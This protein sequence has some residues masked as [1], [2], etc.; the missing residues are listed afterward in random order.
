M[1][2]AERNECPAC[3]KALPYGTAY[4]RGSGPGLPDKRE[5]DCPYCG[6]P[7]EPL[8][9]TNLI[10]LYAILAV[11]IAASRLLGP[12]LDWPEILFLLG[13]AALY[14]AFELRT[15]WTARREKRDRK[16]LGRFVEE[17]HE[18]DDD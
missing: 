13:L 8:R 14:H 4:R 7:L 17:D 2:D 12:L 11:G 5:L 3:G 9:W 10:P 15:W 16:A 18:E 1:A 6:A